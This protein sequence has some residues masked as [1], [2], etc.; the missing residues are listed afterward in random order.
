MPVPEAVESS[1]RLVLSAADALPDV[2]RRSLPKGA[3]DLL[4]I[5][6]LEGRPMSSGQIADLAGLSRPTVLR[7]LRALRDQELVIWEGQSPRDPRA[8]WR[9]R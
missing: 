2:V 4:D 3:R 9:L 8:S 5:L 1:V 7:H 6:R